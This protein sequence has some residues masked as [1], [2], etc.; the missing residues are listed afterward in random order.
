[1]SIDYTVERPI[2][3][4]TGSA[5]KTT[6]KSFIASILR[7]RWII[8]ESSDYWNR[9]DH[10]EKHQEEINF[11]HRAIVL[12]YGMAYP[13]VIEKHCKIIQPNI[14]AITNIGMAHAGNF[15]GKIEGIAAAKSELIKGMSPD[16]HLFLNG[17]DTHSKLLH[18]QNFKGTIKTISIHTP[19]HYQAKNVQYSLDGISFKIRL[20]NKDHTI[21]IPYHGEF[22][23][24]NALLAIAVA[25]LLGF[26]PQEIIQGMNEVKKPRHRLEVFHLQRSITLIDDT[27][28]AFPDAVKGAL[29][30]L[31]EFEGKKKIAV[32]GSM[33]GFG[34]QHQE[35]HKEIGRY[36]VKNK[37]DYLFTYGNISKN[38]GVGARE[39]GMF[40][41]KIFH[42]PR[43]AIDQLHAKLLAT[44]QPN[45]T[46]LVK[47]ASGLKMVDTV[48][49]IRKNLT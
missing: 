8:F 12:E 10:T 25:D 22:H 31:A 28:H 47:G 43:T 46:I 11:I 4:V 36:V 37:I 5:G 16:G 9:T 42:F 23:V 44:I 49:H 19:S 14:G 18:T 21:S 30:V 34:D 40:K 33:P 35:V 29:D 32:L 17:D 38:I 41:N 6:T 24:Y 15:D 26:T 3:A 45:W 7:T 2:I 1:M 48:E 39:A 27:V 13:G 20:G